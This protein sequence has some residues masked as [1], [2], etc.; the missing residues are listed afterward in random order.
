MV[1]QLNSLLKANGMV[2]TDLDGTFLSSDRSA[3][4]ANFATLQELERHKII[5]VIATGRS[6]YSAR[7]VIPRQF[8]IDYLVFSSGAGIIDWHTQRIL[9]SHHLSA[10]EI[11]RVSQRLFH[12][13]LD[14]MIHRPIPENH[15]FWYHTTGR[16]NPDFVRRCELYQAFA[17]PLDDSVFPLEKACQFLIIDSE[18]DS[19]AKYHTLHKQLH[20]LK[21]IRTTSP[22]DG[23]SFWI[24]VFP[25]AV[26]KALASAW[27]AQHHQIEQ[28]N[29]FAL[30]N[31][32]NDLDLLQWAGEGFVVANAPKE[33]KEKYRLVASN[34]HDGFSE[35]VKLWINC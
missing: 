14:F 8:P 6:L 30:G 20:T 35:A 33:L 19:L 34:D 11:H 17:S 10:K 4:P 26:S 24:E 13:E 21:V 15:H 31:D 1:H 2:V 22:L 12:H 28:I 25:K 23:R 9:L 32:Y 3:S 18:E 27:L 16:D 29:I 5:R 7:K